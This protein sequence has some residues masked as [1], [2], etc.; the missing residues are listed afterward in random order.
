MLFVGGLLSLS[1]FLVALTREGSHLPA[2]AQR[3]RRWDR[4]VTA[5]ALLL[6]WALG[7]TLA[8]VGGWYASGW[9][10]A[11]LVLVVLL[12]GLHGILSGRLRRLSGAGPGLSRWTLPLLIVAVTGIAF[13]AVLKP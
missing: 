11:K 3:L 4:A 13:L 9:L 8:S 12:S 5:P 7:I 2:L 6:V 1:L 10:Q